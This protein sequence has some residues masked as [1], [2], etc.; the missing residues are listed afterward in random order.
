MKILI[1]NQS[2]DRW[3]EYTEADIKEE[4]RSLRKRSGVQQRCDATLIIQKDG[5][6]IV[7]TIKDMHGNT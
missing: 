3:T 7:L 5:G 6:N 4:I 1:E 2:A